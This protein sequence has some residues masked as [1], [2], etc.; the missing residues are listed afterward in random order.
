MHRNFPPQPGDGSDGS[1]PSEAW[2]FAQAILGKPIP[3]IIN[4][5]TAARAKREELERLAQFSSRHADELRRLQAAEAEARHKREILEWAA[6]ISTRAEEKLRALQR[7][8]AEEREGWRRAEHFTEMLLEGDWDPS[9]HPRLGGP[10]N[11]GWWAT[12]DGSGSARSSQNA[13]ASFR[14][15]SYASSGEEKLSQNAL[16]TYFKLLYGDKGQKLLKA[17]EKSG[18]RLRIENPWSGKSALDTR[19][20]WRPQQIRLRQDLNP[21]EAAQELMER[22]IDASGLTE[23]RQHLDHTGFPNI[24]ALIQSYKQ[25]VKKAAAFAALISELYLSGVSIASE[26]ADWIVTIH[27]LSEG[28]YYAAIGLLPLLPASVGKT[29][30]ILK[31]GRQS[32]RI[33]AEAVRGAKSL[34]VKELIELLE[35]TRKLA[36]NMVKAGIERPAGTAAHH[37]VPATLEKFIGAKKAREIL[38][39]FGI[40]VENAANGVYLPSKFDD[41]VKAAYH[42]SIHSR[43]YSDEVYK[44]LQKART[45]EDALLI[46]NKI[47][48]ELLTGTFPH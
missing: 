18:G 37:I 45:K 21:A 40:S 32:L 20:H 29:E 48:K 22:L 39:K 19:N 46:L 12:T 2:L 41:A 33:S 8:E 42:G 28:N 5:E 7:K 47:R 3:S 43:R 34:P 10:P 25:S 44:R 11:A 15:A 14:T 16:L 27:D 23:V 30:V 1:P 13:A 35:S 31:H 36:R 38:S 9:K 24:E 17:F 26:G 4:P 6:G